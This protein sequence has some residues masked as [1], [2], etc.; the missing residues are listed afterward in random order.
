[1]K[2]TDII[3]Y[4]VFAEAIV[5]LWKKAAP[6][7]LIREFL[8]SNTPL[9][10]SK[11]NNTHLLQCPYCI[12]VYIGL[13]SFLLYLFNNSVT[14]SIFIYAIVFHRLSNY[15]HMIFSLIHDI[16]LDI[17]IRRCKNE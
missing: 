9:L 12:S 1:M 10:F 5:E 15:I 2:I 4:A 17:R 14:I 16:I 3:I 13:L 7:I 11:T 6:L 8:V